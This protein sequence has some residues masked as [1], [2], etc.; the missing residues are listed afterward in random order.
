MTRNRDLNGVTVQPEGMKTIFK[1][2]KRQFN[3][4]NPERQDYVEY[5]GLRLPLPETRFCGRAWKNDG[6]FVDSA[7]REVGR[8]RQLAGLEEQ[9]ALLDIGSG[10][11]RLAIGLLAELPNIRGYYGVDVSLRS[12]DWC[13]RNISSFHENFKFIHTDI[14]NERYNPHGVEFRKP[15]Q[16]PLADH[17]MDVVFLYSVFTHMMSDDV[18]AYL[19]DM[20]RV[21]RPGGKALFTAFAEKDVKDEEEN[22]EAYL[23]EVVKSQGPLHIVRFRKEFLDDKITSSGFKIVSF[24][25]QAEEVTKQ[26]VYVVSSVG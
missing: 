14:A 9:S 10:Q 19:T 24:F 13:K 18:G 1:R 17:S 2:L 6:F 20:N 7:R 15:I 8:L 3:R 26:S 23:Q 5:E 16:L 12:I 25:H 21:L 11:G 4:R 22:P